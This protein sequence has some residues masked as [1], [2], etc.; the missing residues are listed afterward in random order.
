MARQKM[1]LKRC[2][3]SIRHPLGD[4][5]DGDEAPA[6][7]LKMDDF[8]YSTAGSEGNFPTWGYCTMVDL[9]NDQGWFIGRKEACSESG[10][11]LCFGE[12]QP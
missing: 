5:R 9:P 6:L 7:A 1:D 2:A 3:G 11:Y 12:E 8:H 4:K 10:P